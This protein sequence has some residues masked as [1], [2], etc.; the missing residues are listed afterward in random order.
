[1][2]VSAE[3][4]LPSVSTIVTAFNAANTIERAVASA[5][6]QEYG[7]DH[8]VIVIDDGSTDAT[9]AVVRGLE[10]PN[11][12]F[13]SVEHVGRARALNYALAEAEGSELIANLDADDVMLPGRIGRQSVAFA[14][15]T[16]LGVLGSAYY[17]VHFESN[18][19]AVPSGAF[20]V[21]PPRSNL[22]L[23]RLMAQSFAICHSCATYRRSAAFDVGLFD[24][25]LRSR[26][27]FDLWLRMVTSGWQIENLS[28]VLGVH[29]KASGTSFDR[30]FSPLRSAMEMARLNFGAAKNLGLGSR[31]YL[32]ALL[33][34]GYSLSRR[35]SV[36]AVPRFSEK[37]PVETISQFLE[38]PRGN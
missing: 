14:Q 27:D 2:P 7:G 15:N 13:I 30:R 36:K 3:H 29:L 8:R 26:I 31:G 21:A 11:L 9:A 25:S 23:R 12:T 28:D 32:V 6:E 34:F 35:T 4:S 22:E 38:N 1:M 10:H 5:V 33:R 16:A 24:E 18:V 19:D 20:L 37:V 17:E